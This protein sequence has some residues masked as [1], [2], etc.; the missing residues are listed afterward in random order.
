MRKTPRVKSSSLDRRDFGNSV[1][2]RRGPSRSPG[3]VKVARAR[4]H[5]GNRDPT[6]SMILL[7]LMI[8]RLFGLVT[9]K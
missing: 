5:I 3:N 7:S 8:A 4:G 9:P 1:S 2:T 6:V